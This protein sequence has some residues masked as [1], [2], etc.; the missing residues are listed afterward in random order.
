VHW[1]APKEV[2]LRGP[3][4][5]S[6]RAWECLCLLRACTATIKCPRSAFELVNGTVTFAAALRREF[7]AAVLAC[8]VLLMLLHT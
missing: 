4:A 8:V 2:S 1:L 5:L 7:F 6:L 3:S